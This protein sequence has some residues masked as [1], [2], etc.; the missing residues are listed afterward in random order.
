VIYKKNYKYI[1]ASTGR[2]GSTMIFNS[3][4]SGLRSHY[5]LPYLGRRVDNIY[6]TFVEQ[7]HSSRS[8]QP[9]Y[10][11]HCLPNEINFDMSRVLFIYSCPIQNIKSVYL[12][13][14]RDGFDWFKKHQSN[15][16]GTGDFSKIFE[17]DILNYKLQ[18]QQWLNTQHKN[19]LILN[20][21]DIWFRKSEVCEFL[22]FDIKLPDKSSR[23]SDDNSLDERFSKAFKSE[24]NKLYT[25]TVNHLK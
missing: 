4:I 25:Q 6:G 17:D 22:N 13:T 8:L 1:V 19:V 14:Q 15:L 21:D 18:L 24:M 2:A 23:L 3:L 10:K 9:I 11:T 20:F 7:P 12:R 5:R 16:R